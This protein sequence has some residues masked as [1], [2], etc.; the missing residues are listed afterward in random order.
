[1]AYPAYIRE[2][3]RAL[4]TERHLSIVEIAARLGLPKT[5]VYYWVRDLPLGRS[6]RA[7]PGQ[8]RGN[9]QMRAKYRQRREEAYD[10]GKREFRA[11]ATDPTFRDFVCL[12]L[13]EG[14]KRQRNSV[15]LCNSDAAVV[16]LAAKWMRHFSRNKVTYQ[17]QYHAD[18]NPS[19]LQ[20]YWGAALGVDPEEIRL[21]PK[22]NSSRL[23]SRTWRC[24]NGVCSV[25]A[26][27]TL[28]RARLQAWMDCLQDAWV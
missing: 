15:S 17:V 1:M 16:K 12:Y 21:Q 24:V 2:K 26:W 28:F 6:R 8:R 25:R 4:R 5:T 18:Q 7:N 27:D 14:Y 22:S 20:R 10:L 3:A 19:A 23:S 13:A 11:L 9:R